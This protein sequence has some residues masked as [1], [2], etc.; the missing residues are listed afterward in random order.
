MIVSVILVGSNEDVD[1]SMAGA[2]VKYYYSPP[3]MFHANVMREDE[4]KMPQTTCYWSPKLKLNLIYPW[5]NLGQLNLLYQFQ[6]KERGKNKN[7]PKVW[8]SKKENTV[9]TA[10]SQ[11]S[12]EG[13][14][15]TKATRYTHNKRGIWKKKL[16][17]S[18]HSFLSSF[19]Q[20]WFFIVNFHFEVLSGW[21]SHFTEEIFQA[22]FWH[23][24]K[25]YSNTFLEM[26]ISR[27]RSEIH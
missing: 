9:V 24:R 8:L 20:A 6:R 19:L 18:P 12:Q 5:K 10:P 4:Q 13:V 25:I 26:Y 2:S 17:P 16:P 22:R 3:K 15:S 11:K 7:F 14:S 23:C 21:V 27:C 1:S